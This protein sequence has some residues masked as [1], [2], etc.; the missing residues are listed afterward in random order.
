MTKIDIKRQHD[1]GYDKAHD[2]TDNLAR[3]LSEQFDAECRWEGPELRF[4]RTGASG[5][6][7]V[8]DDEVRVEV[9]LGMLLSP[10]KGKMESVISEKLDRLLK[11]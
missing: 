5:C 1:L 4:E 6:V 10:L 11:T 7:R 8:G 3:E 2:I 9:R